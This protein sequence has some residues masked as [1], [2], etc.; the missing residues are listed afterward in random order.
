MSVISL[1]TSGNT[2]A[3]AFGANNGAS[4]FWWGDLGEMVIYSGSLS[5]SERQQ[6]EAYLKV[7]YGIQ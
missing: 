3:D 7:K 6:I 1:V 2:A 4:S 5:T